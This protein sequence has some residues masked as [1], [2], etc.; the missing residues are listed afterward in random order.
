MEKP[1]RAKSSFQLLDG[2]LVVCTGLAHDPYL[3]RRLLR[4]GDPGA[5]AIVSDVR[6]IGQKRQCLPKIGDDV[7]YFGYFGGDE[8]P[9]ACRGIV[10][11]H[12]ELTN[13]LFDKPVLPGQS[14]SPLLS[15]QTGRVV[16]VVTAT[17]PVT[18]TTLSV[19]ISRATKTEY[20]KK[21]IDSNTPY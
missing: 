15:V 19:G 13:I 11:G 17:V 6:L 3:V 1:P 2:V 14:G 21:L 4:T 16:G 10:A 9:L 20:A 12:D 7:F 8:N 5:V 18:G